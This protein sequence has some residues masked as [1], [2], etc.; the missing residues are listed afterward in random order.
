[1]F[2]GREYVCPPQ[3]IRA[4]EERN[5]QS[6]ASHITITHVFSVLEVYSTHLSRKVCACVCLCV[7]SVYFYGRVTVECVYIQHTTRPFR[8]AGSQ[9]C[10]VMSGS[11]AFRV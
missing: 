4:T 8:V 9:A 3:C 1:V 5:F 2:G 10:I 11:K 6:M 7:L